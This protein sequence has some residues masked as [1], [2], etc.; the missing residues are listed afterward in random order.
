MAPWFAV[1]MLAAFSAC[2]Q[3]HGFDPAEHFEFRLIDGGAAVE[4]TGYVGGRADV[5]IPSHIQGLPVA[6]IGVSAFQGGSFQEVPPGSQYFEWVPVTHPI[7]SV[8]IPSGV[9]Y[10]ADAAFSGNYLS[11][12]IIPYG[13]THIGIAAF[14]VNSITR[15]TI[16]S[17]VAHIGRGAFAL[18]RLTSVTIP[19]SVT[20]IGPWAFDDDV[21]IVRR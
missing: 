6:A 15:V 12:V 4:I 5:R 19:Y 20:Y 9:T 18:N 3:P 17:S 7:Y 8:S 13:V 2:V 1:A 16:P 10:I 21:A 14:Q 11:K